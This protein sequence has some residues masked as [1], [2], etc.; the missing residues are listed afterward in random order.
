MH[1]QNKQYEIPFDR[2]NDFIFDYLSGAISHIEMEDYPRHEVNCKTCEFSGVTC[3][4]D[5]FI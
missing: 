4:F 1:M 5:K 3:M 2:S